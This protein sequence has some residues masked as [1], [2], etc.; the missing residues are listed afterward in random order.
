M[1][2]K[3]RSIYILLFLFLISFFI[4][5]SPL[6][7]GY[8]VPYGYVDT[9]FHISSAL[10]FSEGNFKSLIHP[11]WHLKNHLL[12]DGYD[13]VD[14][15]S[16]S[17]FY[18]PFVNII[19]AFS[20]LFMHAGIASVIVISL[21]YSLSVIS[22][23]FLCKSFNF[24]DVPALV[25][26]ALITV[27]IPL[28]YSQNYG[29][30]TFIIAS[31]FIILSYVFLRC[32]ARKFTWISIIFSFLA[33]ITHWVFLSVVI[34]IG[35]VEL[36]TNKNK[37]AKLYIFLLVLLV[38]PLYIYVFY[39]ANPLSYVATHFSTFIPSNYFLIILA[40]CGFILNFRKYLPLALF[41]LLAVICSFIYYILKISFIFGDMIQ[42]IYPFFISFY[43]G[44]LFQRRNKKNFESIL[45]II[46]LIITV[47][48]FISIQEIFN[49]TSASITKKEFNELLTLREEFKPDDKTVLAVDRGLIPWWITIV[50]K[51]SK[52]VYPGTYD[53][54]D[55]ARYYQNYI[56]KERNTTK[57]YSLYRITKERDSLI[58]KKD[59]WLSI[60]PYKFPSIIRST[61][62]S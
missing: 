24:K 50:S 16:T 38:S 19:L 33:V 18:P 31:N 48:N 23:F 43:V 47:F 10:D 4:R 27:S 51:D 14:R 41:T 62:S 53:T 22:I 60:D 44:S 61:S 58:L 7:Q 2:L 13:I 12:L 17:F 32:K 45:I 20:F 40:I 3:K 36:I 52:I 21:L 54:E 28:I 25:S 1:F 6:Y 11:W 15:N 59:T 37:E 34:I 30:W 42:F 35:L 49:S 9:S 46:I 56:F 26:A 29:F 8:N 5:L 39:L 57:P 55:I